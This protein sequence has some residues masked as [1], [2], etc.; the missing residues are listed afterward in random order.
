MTY[1]LYSFPLEAVE[2]VWDVTVM[3]GG[4]GLVYFAYAIVEQ[5]QAELIQCGDDSEVAVFLSGLRDQKTFSEFV[6]LNLAVS[7]SYEIQL[8]N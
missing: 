6:I 1:F 2:Q 5:L 8:T 3:V 4:V 7:R